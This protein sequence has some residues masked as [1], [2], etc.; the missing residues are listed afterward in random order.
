MTD[1][2]IIHKMGWCLDCDSGDCEHIDNATK[3]LIQSLTESE[4]FI[5]N[6]NVVAADDVYLPCRDAAIKR[7]IIHLTKE[8]VDDAKAKG[9]PLRDYAIAKQKTALGEGK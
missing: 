4:V 8:E 3:S 1:K 2:P 6:G 9:V 7:Y 5:K